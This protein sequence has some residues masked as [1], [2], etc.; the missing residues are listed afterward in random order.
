[1]EEFDAALVGTLIG[2]TVFG[3]IV[4]VKVRQWRG[5][6]RAWRHVC[7]AQ[8][9]STK[10]LSATRP[11]GLRLRL[12]FKGSD[13]RATRLVIQGEMLTPQLDIMRA[14]LSRKVAG[15]LGR[16]PIASGDRRFD[17]GV[18]VRGSRIRG[19]AL[20]DGATRGQIMALLGQRPKGGFVL[21]NQRLQIEVPGFRSSAGELDLLLRQGLH[22]ADR[23]S[24]PPDADLSLIVTATGRETSEGARYHKLRWLHGQGEREALGAAVSRCMTHPVLSVRVGVARVLAELG[25]VSVMERLIRERT[26]DVQRTRSPSSVVALSAVLTAADTAGLQGESIER[27]RAVGRGLQNLLIDGLD[28]QSASAA[29]TGLGHFGTLAAIRHIRDA[30]AKGR[31]SRACGE[32]AITRLQARYGD[33][34]AGGLMLADEGLEGQLSVAEVDEGRGSVSL[35]DR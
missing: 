3:G 24:L 25:H 2:T 27:A 21:H 33:T 12:S 23:F 6:R 14:A 34:H 9:L 30:I 8:G 15:L 16:V 13:A 1:M 20:L 22:L 26:E 10:G 28:G 18:D 17:E 5:R 4:A 29:A 35:A 11:D 19:L 32:Q 31:I 7:Q